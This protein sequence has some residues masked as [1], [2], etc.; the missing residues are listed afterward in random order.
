M[1]KVAAYFRRLAHLYRRG[2]GLRSAKQ[3]GILR[4]RDDT[5]IKCDFATANPIFHIY[6]SWTRKRPIRFV[7]ASRALGLFSRFIK[8]WPRPLAAKPNRNTNMAAERRRRKRKKIL[9]ESFDRARQ[10]PTNWSSRNWKMYLRK[11]LKILERIKFS[12]F[13]CNLT[14][15]YWQTQKIHEFAQLDWHLHQIWSEGCYRG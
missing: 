15:S 14:P 1:F 11:L 3:D 8:R 10:I 4:R 6:V 13:T 9:R 7:S 2:G 5:D 12:H